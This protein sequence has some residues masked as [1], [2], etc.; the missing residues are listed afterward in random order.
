V[1]RAKK[2]LT[3]GNIKVKRLPPQNRRERGGPGFVDDVRNLNHSEERPSFG[4]ERSGTASLELQ[5]AD[6]SGA[7]TP[8]AQLSM[9]EAFDRLNT[10][11]LS[12]HSTSLS[13][14]VSSCVELQNSKT[15]CGLTQA[16]TNIAQN[17]IYRCAQIPNRRGYTYF[18]MR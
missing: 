11:E 5:A 6:S 2:S 1:F 8:P 10:K 7:S 12:C 3:P 16:E 13:T 17:A 15:D 9:E 4:Q 18:Y 14:G